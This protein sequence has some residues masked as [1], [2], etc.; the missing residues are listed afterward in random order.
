MVQASAESDQATVD[1]LHRAWRTRERLVIEWRG[2]LPAPDPMLDDAFHLLTPAAEL[3]GERL[4]FAATANAVNLL[5]PRPMFEPVSLA[6]AAGAAPI[7]DDGP[8]DVTIPSGEAVLA[9]GGPLALLDRDALDGVAVVPRVHLVGGVLRPQRD[10]PPAPSADLADDQLAAVGHEGG[11]ARIIAPAG[12]GKT[13]V[14]TERTRHLVLDRG[15]AASAVSLVAYNRRARL[16]MAERL[17]DVAGLD[18]RTLNSLALAIATGSGPF[19]AGTRQRSL[20]TISELDARR[21]L[22]RVVPGRRRRQLTDPLE[23]W[24]DALSACRLGLRDPA[25]IE[26]TYGGDV[27]GFPE[28]L[29]AYRA[30]LRRRGELDF[31]EQ[32]LAALDV[33]LTEPAA[34]AAARRVAPVLLIDEFQDLTPA[35]LL[36]VRLLAGPAAEVVAVGD[37][38]QTIY[39]YSGASPEWLVDFDRF[40]PGAADHPLTINYRCPP[41]V[42]T[43]ADNLLSHNRYRV[44]KTINPSP[45]AVTSQAAG[46]VT[47]QVDGQVT[48]Q[49]DGRVEGDGPRPGPGPLVVNTDEEPQRRLVAHVEGLLAAGA[50][51]SDIAVLARVNAALLPP[52]VFLAD[53]GIPVARP[54]GVDRSMLER[55]GVGA[56]L[57]WLRLA[58]APEQRLRADDLRM[59]VRRPPRSLHPRIAD[60]VCE[61]RSVKELYGLAGR[62][63]KEREAQIVT[64]LTADIERLR[65]RADGGATAEELL[66]EIYDGIGLLGA[67]SQLDQSQRTARRAAHADE[68]AAL[69]AL[70]SIGPGPDEL[71]PWIVD[72]LEGLPRNDDPDRAPAVTLATIHSTKGLEWPHVIVHDVRGD[73]HP[74]RLA[75]DTEEERRI[76]HVAL[77]RCRDSVLVNSYPA[78][79]AQPRSPFV[80]D[81]RAKRAE[82]HPTDGPSWRERPARPTERRAKKPA[83]PT[84]TEPSSPEAAKLRDALADWRTQRCKTDGVPA[85]IV[86]DNATLDA[87]AEA[88]PA[89]LVALGRIKGIGPTKLDRYGSDILGVVGDA[90][91]GD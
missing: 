47:G 25:E 74:H 36:L 19:A 87:I 60:W 61:Q 6:I 68:L 4:R 69:R 76:F 9:D 51:P 50:E 91:P 89:S 72:H 16:E 5:G 26:S 63:N 67:A 14:L 33:L 24:I 15:V 55:S 53:A 21:L 13:R 27:A 85:Y 44:P 83:K 40:F 54:V 2:P 11:P 88:A 82:P 31:D 46:Q 75:T 39:G 71:E 1:R 78:D 32:I 23:P 42:V 3:P 65:A 84:R 12:S 49:V 20:T 45:A 56:A 80:A 30:E 35:H 29:Q 38:D 58:S 77:T 62:L 10:E 48:G 18:I 73:L 79:A 28:V 17:H 41:D 86:L 22:D 57:G 8:G 7:A 64:E 70:A 59:A 66:D 37:D 52:T 90:G 81:L 34:R 43:A